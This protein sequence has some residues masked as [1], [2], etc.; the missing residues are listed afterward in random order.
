MFK[1]CLQIIESLVQSFEV[2]R[3]GNEP[4]DF[5]KNLMRK[6]GILSGLFAPD[7]LGAEC[8]CAVSPGRLVLFV[9]GIEDDEIAFLSS[10]D[11]GIGWECRC[12]C[13][14]VSSSER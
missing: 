4:E 12:T 7:E 14:P 9:F 6:L 10:V 3:T 2:G 8:P 5:R 1:T 13:M 11:I